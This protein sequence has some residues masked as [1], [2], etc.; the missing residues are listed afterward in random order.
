[1]KR[2]I[3]L[4]L[5]TLAVVGAML[6]REAEGDAIYD[7]THIAGPW[8]FWSPSGNVVD[9]TGLA[10][11][12]LYLQ[13]WA[14]TTGHGIALKPLFVTGVTSWYDNNIQGGMYNAY[15]DSVGTVRKIRASWRILGRQLG[16][17]CVVG[18]TWCHSNTVPHHA[19][20]DS[21][22][23]VANLGRRSVTNPKIGLVAVDSANVADDAIHLLQLADTGTPATNELL[24]V[25]NATHG[26]VGYTAAIDIDA[27]TMDQLTVV[28]ALDFGS[29]TASAYD[30]MMVAHAE[31]GTYKLAGWPTGT[32]R[33]ALSIPGVV[34]DDT[35]VVSFN[36]RE[37][38]QL[39]VTVGAGVREAGISAFCK[40]DSV[41]IMTGDAY[42]SGDTLA[43]YRVTPQ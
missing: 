33:W 21:C 16:D 38:G 35:V 18:T 40:V 43:D 26:R 11:V 4:M 27:A 3:F 5:A 7:E 1:M 19:L 34:T 15:W 31:A 8:I 14:D 41:I 9:T 29:V 6:P 28:G 24:Y 32:F 22:V 17:T 2:I 37:Q 13:N 10:K 30:T 39:P 12:R 42:A 23:K 20:T 25:V 36:T